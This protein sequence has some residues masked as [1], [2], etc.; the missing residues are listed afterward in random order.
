[1]ASYEDKEAGK[2]KLKKQKDKKEKSRLNRTLKGVLLGVLFVLLCGVFIGCLVGG[3]IAIKYQKYAKKLVREGGEG[4]FKANQT[5]IIYDDKGNV[6]TSLIGDRD[7]YYLDYPEIPYFIKQALIASEDR[8]FYEHSGVDLKAVTRAAVE[9]FKND[10]EIT[11][12]GS[13]ITQQ[14]ARNVFLSHEVTY[15][16]K[17]KEMFIAWEL[18]D[19]YTKDQILEFYI[20][21]I[22]FANGYYG[23]EAAAKGYFN[24]TVSKLSIGEMAFICAIPNNPSMYDPYVNSSKTIERKNRIIKQMYD[25][26]KIDKAMYEEAL[27]ETIVLLPSKNEKNNYVETY[28]RYCATVALMK[29]S[30]FQFKYSFEN[31]KEKDEYN[32]KYNELYDNISAKLY[33]GGYR[34]YTSISLEKQGILQN[35]IDEQLRNYQDVNEDGIYTYQGAATCIDNITGKVIAIVGGRSQE[36]KGY[37]LN[38]AYQS[39][40]QPGSSIKPLLVYTPIFERGIFPETIVKDEKIQDG[41]VNSPNIY[42]GDIS[43]RYAVEKSKN[44]IAWDLFDKL[45]PKVGLSYLLNMNFKKIVPRDY[46]NAASI[47][48]LTYGVSTEEMAAGFSALA[49]EGVYTSPTCIVKITDNDYTVIVDNNVSE[50]SLTTVEKKEIYATNASRMMNDVLK[51]VLVNGT[52]KKYNISNAI[53]CAKTGTTNSNKDVW[54]SGYSQYYTTAVW[55]GYDMPKEI[56]DGYGTT[57]SGYIW[58]KYMEKIHSGLEIKDFIPYIN[59]DGKLSNGQEIEET[60]EVMDE[61]TTDIQESTNIDNAESLNTESTSIEN[62]LTTENQNT[63]DSENKANDNTEIST[64]ENRETQTSKIYEEYEPETTRNPSTIGGGELYTEYWGE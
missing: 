46:V 50:N 14:L 33:T 15:Q 61:T 38:R 27:L 40:R 19:T 2:Q 42:D 3:N 17:I 52:G 23:I 31:D 49:N 54:F 34:I 8:K 41:P 55:S 59:Q 62:M 22:Y 9:L 5:S 26:G 20:N 36:Y 6:I 21:N 18:E 37:T 1:M 35:T 12:G 44:T 60:S 48:G 25:L 29:N 13:T 16:R 43:I 56:N 32:N 39:F 58:Q 7:S 53:C 63:Q 45:T 30:G 10:G 11:Q 24:K 47:G 51:G 28:V 4:I 57:C 64:T